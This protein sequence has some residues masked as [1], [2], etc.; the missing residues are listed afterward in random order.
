MAHGHMMVAEGP[1]YRCAQSNSKV[2]DVSGNLK[3]L[4]VIENSVIRS[5]RAVMSRRHVCQR[6]EVPEGREASTSEQIG[7]NIMEGAQQRRPAF[8]AHNVTRNARFVCI[9]EHR[10]NLKRRDN[11]VDLNSYVGKRRCEDEYRRRCRPTC[12]RQRR[13]PWLQQQPQGLYIS[14]DSRE[15]SGRDR[16]W[17]I[18]KPEPHG[19]WHISEM[20]P[21]LFGR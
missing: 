1:K 5:P 4:Y 21:T 2:W 17:A 8:T 14:E 16:S 20:L 10:P 18:N 15:A 12:M 13:S 9:R 3:G 7:H 6:S 19:D 11:E